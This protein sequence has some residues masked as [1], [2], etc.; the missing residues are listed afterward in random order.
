MRRYHAHQGNALF[1]IL[2]AVALFA[3]LSYAITSSSRNEGSIDKESAS[4][5]AA[6]I[7][8]YAATV[9]TAVQRMHLSGVGENDFCFDHPGW[10]HTNYDHAGCTNNA[11]RLF[12]TD[13]GG[14]VFQQDMAAMGGDFFY[15]GHIVIAEVGTAAPSWNSPL[16]SEL[17]MVAPIE[18]KEVCMQ[19]NDGLGIIN[20]RNHWQLGTRMPHDPA[21]PSSGT[22]FAG[23]YI[24][25]VTID[26]QYNELVGKMSGCY[27]LSS[28]PNASTQMYYYHLLHQR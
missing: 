6:A 12:H 25:N 1:I 10:G 19:I 27:T 22:G 16:G 17:V 28:S 15:T 3:A 7:L 8:N 5:Q 11:N 24:A 21:N 20:Y 9:S 14:V 13:G 2:I 18:N 23:S 26:G 4:L